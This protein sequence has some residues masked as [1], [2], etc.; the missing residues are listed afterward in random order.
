V[1]NLAVFQARRI[2]LEAVDTDVTSKGATI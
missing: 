1:K 2:Q